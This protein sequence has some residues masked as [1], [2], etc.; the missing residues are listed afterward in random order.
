MFMQVS[1]TMKLNSQKNRLQK[2]YRLISVFLALIIFANIAVIVPGCLPPI[3]YPVSVTGYKLDTYVTLSAYTSGGHSAEE[4]S[5]I[6]SEA[7]ALCDKYELLFSRTD[8]R[9]TLY[10]VN[11]GECTN[12]PK[13]LAELILLGTDYGRISN[14]LFDIS[15]GS[16]S[17][18]WDFT[19]DKPSVPDA[20]AISEALKHVDYTKIKLAE[21]SDGT[22]D[23]D[24]PEGM[25]LDLGAIAKGY[26]AD[27]L[28]EFLLEKDIDRAIINLG[29]NVLCIGAKTSSSDFTIGIKK[30]FANDGT[31]LVNLSLSDKSAVSSGTYERY[32]KDGDKFYHHILNP[33]TGYPYDNELCG[34]TIVSDM[35]VTGDCLSTTCFALGLDKGMELI[36]ATENVE[37]VFVTNDGQT[38]YSSGFAKY[39]KK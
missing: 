10:K 15:I 9:S 1:N 29:G 7:L 25:I 6:L 37:A 19:A 18:L 24:I 14:G 16:V 30:P 38:H 21:C 22:Y 13:E 36:E 34:V 4:L 20:A 12:I 2:K 35:S 3:K 8:S 28:K 5:N 27:R 39:I 33:A 11:N 17:S 31:T 26:I 32:F 23:I